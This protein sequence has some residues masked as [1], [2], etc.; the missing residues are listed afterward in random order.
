MHFLTIYVI[1]FLVIITVLIFVHEF[2]HYW[3]A[4]KYGVQVEAFSIG[5]GPELFGYTD[6]DGTRWKF[7]AIPFGGYVMMH[8]DKNAASAPSEE[9]IG[10]MDKNELTKTLFGKTPLQRIIVSLAGPGAN[11]VYSILVFILVYTMCGRPFATNIVKETI[12]GL[13]AAMHDI[14]PGDTII[15][16]NDK[17]ITKSA[18]IALAMNE[19]KDKPSVRVSRLRDQSIK[20]FDI[21]L[22][23]KKMLGISFN[24]AY[25]HLGFFSGIFLAIF[26]CFKMFVGVLLM[27][28][29]LCIGAVSAS[30][31]GGPLSIANMLGDLAAGG[32]IAYILFFS[33]ILGVNLAALNLFPLP[34]LDGG[35]I[36]FD[37]LEHFGY[38]VKMEYREKITGCFFLLLISFM[39]FTTYNDVMKFEF[40]KNLLK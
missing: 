17:I 25:E 38:K 21:K 4:K 35:N 6:K 28:I 36:L 39:I 27:F 16:I 26:D 24:T 11:L 34:A 19:A 20:T 12:T 10:Q 37:T 33:A 18:D 8:G 15:G 1:P 29:R 23:G 22:S 13:P 9:E 3:F 2:G 7:S 32:D 14:K 30:T 31:I 5:M 40:V